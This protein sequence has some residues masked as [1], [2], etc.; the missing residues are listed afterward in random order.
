[1]RYHVIG[2]Q[3]NSKMCLV[4]GLK[5]ALGLKAAFYELENSELLAVCEPLE[6]HQSYPS[7]L[8]G[9]IVAALLDETIGRAILTKYDGA[10][11]SRSP[12]MGSCGS[13]RASPTREGV[14][15]RAPASY[16]CPM[17]AWGQWDPVSI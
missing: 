3:P 10:T 17:A 1:M 7:R 12:W 8:H 16:Y 14:F 5:N 9:G 6:E 2:K 4:C 13:S 11:K 15:L